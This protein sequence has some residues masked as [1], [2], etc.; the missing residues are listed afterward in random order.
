[1]VVTLTCTARTYNEGQKPDGSS[2]AKNIFEL[3]ATACNAGSTCPDNTRL[4][5]PDYVER[6][7][8]ASLRIAS[9]GTDCY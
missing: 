3:T 9:D 8:S 4:P 5:D 6:R 1:M 7:R 2:F